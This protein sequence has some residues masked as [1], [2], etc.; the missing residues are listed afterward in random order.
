MIFGSSHALS[1]VYNIQIGLAL[2]MHHGKV[3]LVTNKHTSQGSQSRDKVC[4]I[5]P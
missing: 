2:M 3:G 5:N 4:G 1:E